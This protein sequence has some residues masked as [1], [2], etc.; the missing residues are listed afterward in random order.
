MMQITV[1][2]IVVVS[3]FPVGAKDPVAIFDSV[4]ADEERK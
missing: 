3:N 4:Q 1:N 2:D